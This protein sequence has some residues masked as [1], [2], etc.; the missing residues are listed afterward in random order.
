MAVL[1]DC[2]VGICFSYSFSPAEKV[3][4]STTNVDKA[5]SPALTGKNPCW[6][7]FCSMMYANLIV[8]GI[9]NSRDFYQL[10][11]CMDQGTSRAC[12]LYPGGT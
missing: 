7:L 8:E 4:I 9:L 1:V 12:F 2:C 3:G 6:F 5:R 11:G 10:V